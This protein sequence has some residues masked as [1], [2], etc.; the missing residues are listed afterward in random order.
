MLR[1]IPRSGAPEDREEDAIVTTAIE[2]Y[3]DILNKGREDGLKQSVLSV[4][5]AR[6]LDVSE[7]VERAINE[8]S[9]EQLQRWLTA[10]AI[11]DSAEALLN[12]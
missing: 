8:G 11:V 10:A 7:Q 12:E 1:S 5:R 6:G 2:T 9:T 4:L 3:Q